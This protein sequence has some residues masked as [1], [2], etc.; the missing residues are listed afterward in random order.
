MDTMSDSTSKKEKESSFLLA[1]VKYILRKIILFTFI[2]LVIMLFSTVVFEKCGQPIN[3]EGVY[4]NLCYPDEISL[5]HDILAHVFPILATISFLL[6][7]VFMTSVLWFFR[8][9][10]E[11]YILV[12]QGGAVKG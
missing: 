2:S 12:G 8:G 9:I 3:W 11:G 5:T 7:L 4:Y 1:V 6:N 10:K